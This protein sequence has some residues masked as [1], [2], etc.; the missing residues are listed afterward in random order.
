MGHVREML[1]RETQS[2]ACGYGCLSFLC[3]ED[4]HSGS[5]LSEKA[6]S[7]SIPAYMTTSVFSFFSFFF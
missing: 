1:G 5:T 4:P 2:E 6:A 7:T 3:V